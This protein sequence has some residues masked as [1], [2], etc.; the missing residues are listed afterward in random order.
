M[1][2]K[3]GI[4]SEFGLLPQKKQWANSVEF[5]VVVFFFGGGATLARA[6]LPGMG[7]FTNLAPPNLR[8]LLSLKDTAS[9]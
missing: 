2:P 6:F 5:V 3:S 9:A 8:P 7:P 4:F 1:P